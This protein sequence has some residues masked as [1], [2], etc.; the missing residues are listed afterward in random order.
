VHGRAALSTRKKQTKALAQPGS[1]CPSAGNLK[2]SV[3]SIDKYQ[4]TSSFFEYDSTIAC[5][6]TW[7]DLS[8]QSQQS[9]GPRED[10]LRDDADRERFLEF[11]RLTDYFTNEKFA[12]NPAVIHAMRSKEALLR[13]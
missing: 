11:H 5:G 6:G 13:R 7:R 1:L 10:I 2:G 4:A 9:Q 12:V 3:N 8:P